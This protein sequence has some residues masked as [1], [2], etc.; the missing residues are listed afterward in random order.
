[1][2]KLRAVLSIMRVTKIFVLLT[3]CWSGLGTVKLNNLPSITNDEHVTRESQ[4]H[5]M[6][7]RKMKTEIEDHLMKN[8]RFISESCYATRMKSREGL[9]S[10]LSPQ[11]KK[12]FRL[13]IVDTVDELNLLFRALGL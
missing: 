4:L 2:W 6:G 10:K 8:L 7:D 5:K 3:T 9:S 11:R 1:M 12:E 13:Q